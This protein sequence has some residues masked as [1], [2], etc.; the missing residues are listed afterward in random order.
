MAIRPTA[1]AGL[2]QTY[3]RPEMTT[4]REE[5]KALL[6]RQWSG[7]ASHRRSTT[8]PWHFVIRPDVLELHA[9]NDRQLRALDPTGR[10]M[11]LSCGCALFN[12]RVGLGR[13]PP[14]AG[15]P[16]AGPYEA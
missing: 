7:P 14:R 2:A 11:V 1:G 6:R 10:Q 15:G 9:D 12:A 13:R 3:G 4:V 8:Q 5:T 16:L